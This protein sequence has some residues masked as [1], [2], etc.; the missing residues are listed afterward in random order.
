M[1]RGV[2]EEVSEQEEAQYSRDQ[3]EALIALLG[4]GSHVLFHLYTIIAIATFNIYQ[5]HHMILPFPNSLS[6]SP[7]KN[8]ANTPR[9]MTPFIMIVQIIFYR[10][11]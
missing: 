8:R 6:N 7:T 1:G 2:H 11:V 10:S 4:N 9:L 3:T 5:V